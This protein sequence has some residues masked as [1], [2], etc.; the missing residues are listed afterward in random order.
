MGDRNYMADCNFVEW[1][2]GCICQALTL[3]HCGA[4]YDKEDIVTKVMSAVGASSAT[5]AVDRARAE[6]SLL[7]DLQHSVEPCRNSKYTS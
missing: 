4:R 6:A 2:D 3:R 7:G 5:P 1:D